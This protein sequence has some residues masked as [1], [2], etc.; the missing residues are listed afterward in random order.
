MINK[1]DN[2]ILLIGIGVVFYLFLTTYAFLFQD[3]IKL[4]ALNIGGIPAIPLYFF[5]EL[6]YF[7]VC[8]VFSFLFLQILKRKQIPSKKIF[9]YLVAFMAFGQIL[10]FVTY[11]ILNLLRSSDYFENSSNFY[12]EIQNNYMFSTIIPIRALLLDLFLIL[13][14]YKN[15]NLILKIDSEPQEIEKIGT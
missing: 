7:I 2:R 9:I 15:R 4:I 13:I 1:L 14:F 3:W 5:L 12:T 8:V 10:Q 6:F 11:P